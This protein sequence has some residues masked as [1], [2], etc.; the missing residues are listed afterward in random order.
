MAWTQSDVDAL[1]AAIADG[2]GARSITFGDQSVTFGTV[3]EM[4]KL[5]AVMQADVTAS[6]TGTSTRRRL[7]ATCKGV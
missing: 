4:L 2:R 5:L 6:T 1:K 3:D 7:A